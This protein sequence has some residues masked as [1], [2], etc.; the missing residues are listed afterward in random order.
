MQNRTPSRDL[1]D[2]TRM[3][4]LSW[5]S[6]VS[7]FGKAGFRDQTIFRRADWGAPRII[8]GMARTEAPGPSARNNLQRDRQSAEAGIDLRA[9]LNPVHALKLFGRA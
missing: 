1:A 3:S 4:Q 2:A 6:I 8:D 5:S 7:A 9:D